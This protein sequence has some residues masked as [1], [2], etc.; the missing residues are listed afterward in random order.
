MPKSSTP[1]KRGYHTALTRKQARLKIHL[2]QRSPIQ[3]LIQA[4]NYQEPSGAVSLPA[5]SC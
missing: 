3:G 4:G 2:V 5:G 1:G